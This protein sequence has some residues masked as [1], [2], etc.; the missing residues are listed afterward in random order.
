[1]SPVLGAFLRLGLGARGDVLLALVLCPF[2][3][4]YEVLLQGPLLLL[5]PSSSALFR[6][7]LR[8]SPLLQLQVEKFGLLQPYVIST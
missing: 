2:L 3:E 4:T 8:L 5:R 1:M 7:L 6:L